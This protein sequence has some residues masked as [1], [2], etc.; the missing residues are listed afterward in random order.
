MYKNFEFSAENFTFKHLAE[1]CANPD[2]KIFK[3]HTHITCEIY[4]FISGKGTFNIEGTKYIL[5]SGDILIM[6]DT[7]SHFIEI[8]PD[9]TYERCAIN[10]KKDFVRLIDKK[11]FLL[12]AFENRQPGEH[13]LY[14][15]QNFKN[16][17]YLEFLQNMMDDSPE[18]ELQISINL[19]SL[20]G[21]IRTAYYKT[22]AIETPH[23][24]TDI[25]KIIRYIVKNLDSSLS[26]DMICEHFYI[27]KPHLCRV[28]KQYMGCS[29]WNYI[30][31]KRLVKARAMIDSG[32]QPTKIFA[33][34]GFSD[35]STFFKAYKKHFGTPPKEIKK[36]K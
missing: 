2:E 35:Y 6:N 30:T 29:V 36:L 12:E 26:L 25:N 19:L 14:R 31:I 7:E 28:F 9:S 32:Q 15:R 33:E 11:G 5:Q 10:F 4:Y 13:N 27:S 18:K 34:C 3:M 8:S 22:K 1:A 21:E 24:K 20:L 16:E 23:L 17:N